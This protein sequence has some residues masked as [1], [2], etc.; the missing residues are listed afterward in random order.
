MHTKIPY[1][2]V[3]CLF[4]FY[5][6]ALADFKDD[7]GYTRLLLE[8]GA[9][10]P[11]GSGVLVTQAEALSG[12]AYMPNVADAQFTGKTITD[13]SGTNPPGSSSG[14]ATAVGRLFYGNSSS[15]APAIDTVNAY[16]ANTW[17]GSDYL[18][19]TNSIS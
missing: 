9:N 15:I 17:L 16:D 11:D 5:G 18:R 3:L 13:Q 12:D 8:L 2:L 6:I 10:V 14:H 4:S 19:A 1:P 7:I